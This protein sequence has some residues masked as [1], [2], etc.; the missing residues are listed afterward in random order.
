MTQTPLTPAIRSTPRWLVILLFL[1]AV[2]TL[3]AAA[4]ETAFVAAR[5]PQARLALAFHPSRVEK[6]TQAI[7]NALQSAPLEA[8]EGLQSVQAAILFSQA[9]HSGAAGNSAL[10][11]AETRAASLRTT[12]LGRVQA[13]AVRL[14]YGERTGKTAEQRWQ[15]IRPL[16]EGLEQARFT[17]HLGPLRTAVAGGYR[18]IRV[19]PGSAWLFADQYIG[20]PHGPLLQYFFAAVEALAQ[21]RR[22]AGDA[23]AAALLERVRTRWLRQWLIEPGPLELRLL[24]A[25]L[26]RGDSAA[27]A[28]EK[29]EAA[30]WRDAILRAIRE[31]R[32]GELGLTGGAQFASAE[33]ERVV[34][35]LLV[36]SW[37]LSGAVAL[38]AITVCVGWTW[39]LRPRGE[40]GFRWIAARAAAVAALLL[41]CGVLCVLGATEWLRVDLRRDWSAPLYWWRHPFVAAGAAMVLL[42]VVAGIGRGGAAVRLQR[43]GA[44]A[45]VGW[46]LV[47]GAAFGAVRVTEAAR[48]SYEAALEKQ[49][50]G[51]SA[52]AIVGAERAGL[53]RV[54]A[55]SRS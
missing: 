1:A 15:A 33:H 21:D 39:L 41:I 29:T 37:L 2:G 50:G 42:F 18:A 20:H 3:A 22:N 53:P 52:A 27:G 7:G 28:E 24:A 8:R 55:A 13:A 49:L 43:V 54:S 17:H 9:L 12:Q 19:E 10:A 11:D 26:L 6:T 14:L 32:Q 23:D 40:L 35:R 47:G 48:V 5:L 46:L 31:Q 25:D 4:M 45:L 38:L 51:D 44:T 34:S 30:A 16:L 36:V